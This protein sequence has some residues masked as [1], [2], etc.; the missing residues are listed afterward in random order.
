MIHFPNKTLHRYTYT[1]SSTGVYGET[2][3]TWE[4][5]DDIICD[6]QNEN[7]A[8]TAKQYGVEKQNLYNIHID[9]DTTISKSD[10]LR[11]DNGNKYH[12]IGEPKV[13]DH[14]HNYQKIHLVRE[15]A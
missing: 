1:A 9:L 3:Y 14:F 11:D 6:F 7:N 5:S 13:Y 2:V 15:R 10:Q 4:Y 8:E 12:I